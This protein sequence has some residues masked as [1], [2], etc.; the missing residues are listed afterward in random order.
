MGTFSF[1]NG[2][3]QPTWNQAQGSYQP[4][5]LSA[6]QMNTGSPQGMDY[7]KVLAAGQASPVTDGL[8]YSKLG[9]WAIQRQQ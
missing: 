9:Q 2:S 4:D 3:M 7:S 1:L 8:D 6:Y 5:V